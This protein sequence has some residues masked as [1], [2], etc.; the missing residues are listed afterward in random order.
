[1]ISELYEWDDKKAAKNLKKHG[2]AFDLAALVFDDPL[3]GTLYDSRHSIGEDRYTVL[4]I[5][6]GMK[7]LLA[8]AY[9]VRGARIRIINARGATSKET[10]RY[11]NEDFDRIADAADDFE[12]EPEYDFRG[13]VR[14]LVYI[15]GTWAVRLDRDVA[16]HYRLAKDVNDALRQLIAE[17]RAPEAVASPD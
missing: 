12:M 2:V 7:T 3:G 13:M 9:V 1:V 14:G 15:P 11:M 16:K 6:P 8:V 10:R 4:G 5:P 17:G